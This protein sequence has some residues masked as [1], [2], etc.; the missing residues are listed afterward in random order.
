M[1]RLLLFLEPM[2]LSDSLVSAQ[3]PSP[4]NHIPTILPSVD[5]GSVSCY[6]EVH[7]VP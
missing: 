2:S 3:E 6:R 7:F 1:S 4:P 5:V